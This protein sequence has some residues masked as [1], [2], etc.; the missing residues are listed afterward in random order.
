MLCAG[1][2]SLNWTPALLKIKSKK[3]KYISSTLNS[4]AGINILFYSICHIHKE[5]AALNFLD[6]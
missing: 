5:K 1:A 3:A 4:K 2:Q 6:F